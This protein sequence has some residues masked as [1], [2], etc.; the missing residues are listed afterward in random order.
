MFLIVA[1]RIAVAS[2]VGPSHVATSGDFPSFNARLM[3]S[4][5]TTGSSTSR[6][7]AMMSEATDTCCRSTPRTD[8]IPN[9]IATVIGIESAISSAE[10]HSQKPI[11][12]TSTTR[13]MAS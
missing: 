3:A 11:S 2:F 10:R 12:A 6:P 1:K 13:M 9:V 4:P 8:I 7:R 5:A